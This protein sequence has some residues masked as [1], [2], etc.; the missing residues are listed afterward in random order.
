MA[1]ITYVPSRIGEGYFADLAAPVSGDDDK[2][3]VYD[4]GTESYVY[5]TTLTNYTLTTPT[6]ASFANATH[7]H[8]DAA[9]GGALDHGALTGLSD[10]DHT[11]YLLATGSRAG[12]T[13]SLQTLTSG[14]VTPIIRSASDSTTAVRV[15]N[16]AGSSDVIVVDTTND[17]VGVGISPDTPLHILGLHGEI[18]SQNTA[19]DNTIKFGRFTTANYTNGEFPIMGFNVNSLSTASWLSFGGGSSL[20]Y[21]VTRMLFYAAANNTTLTGTE[22]MRLTSTGI[23]VGGGINPAALLDISGSS[24]GAASLRIRSGTAPTSPNDGDIWKNTDEFVM[25]ASSNNTNTV[26][27]ALRLRRGSSGTPAAGFGGAYE[28]QLKSSTT[29]GQNAGRLSWEWATA[30]HASRASRG[31]LSAYYTSTERTPI[32]WG[33]DSSET[34]LGFHGTTP[35]AQSAAYTPSNVSTDRSYDA[36]STTLAEV[37]DVLGT[38]IADLQAVGLIG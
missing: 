14:I 10:D 29:A 2:A 32:Q 15:Q 19:A 20:S 35:V 34:L 18:R 7:D 3:L 9:G 17:R 26:L 37:A 33:A 36:D 24:S 11:Q 22:V 25:H 23:Q 1:T 8:A 5:T 13:S 6:I 21:A 12:A 27:N 30:T 31:K 28:M 16:A 4:H 38:L